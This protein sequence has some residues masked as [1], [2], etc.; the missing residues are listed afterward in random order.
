MDA[1]LLSLLF[2]VWILTFIWRYAGG[3]G[4]QIAFMGIWSQFPSAWKQ[5]SEG[6]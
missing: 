6:L 4:R 3:L 2:A 1:N 5:T